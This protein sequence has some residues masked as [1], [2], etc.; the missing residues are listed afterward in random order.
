[1]QLTRGRQFCFLRGGLQVFFLPRFS[2][3]ICITGR[4]LPW[5]SVVKVR[6]LQSNPPPAPRCLWGPVARMKPMQLPESQPR[7]QEALVKD[8]PSAGHLWTPQLVLGQVNGRNHHV[9]KIHTL[10]FSNWFCSKHTMWREYKIQKWISRLERLL[11]NFITGDHCLEGIHLTES[12]PVFDRFPVGKDPGRWGWKIPLHYLKS[13]TVSF[14]N[15]KL[16]EVKNFRKKVDTDL[17]HPWLKVKLLCKKKKEKK[18][19]RPG[20]LAVTSIAK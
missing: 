6:K 5:V 3:Q 16:S 4:T 14:D 18:K 12:F 7:D 10:A 2:G 20:C 9:S 17:Q 13:S 15:R 11:A 19:I 1:M 8:L